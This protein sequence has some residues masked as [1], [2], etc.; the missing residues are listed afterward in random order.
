M[1]KK[2]NLVR[3]LLIFVLLL[4]TM[5]NYGLAQPDYTI[6]TA[7]TF[8]LG[9]YLVDGQGRTL[10]Y[11][12]KDAPGISNCKG[13]CHVNWPTF[14]TAKIEVPLG[15]IASDFSSIT[16]DDGTQQTTF[17]GWPLYY[18]SKDIVAGDVKGQKINDVWFVISV[19]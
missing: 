7:N 13:Q 14:Y 12:T 3:I 18:F 6:M 8:D 17:R 4:V 9:S 1:K 5:T 19:N 11:S 15:L 16:R 2:A 10:Y